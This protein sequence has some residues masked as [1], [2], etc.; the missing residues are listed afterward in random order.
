[1]PGF[2]K[3]DVPITTGEEAPPSSQESI[4]E[5]V[6]LVIEKEKSRRVNKENN[7]DADKKPGKN[8]RGPAKYHQ[9]RESLVWK[10]KVL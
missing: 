2:L 5:V 10:S 1:M 7:R 3:D 8:I 9:T 4:P 6:W